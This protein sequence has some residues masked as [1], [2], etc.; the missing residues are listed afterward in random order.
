MQMKKNGW[1]RAG[2]ILS[3]IFLLAGFLPRQ[4]Q[5]SPAPN[6]A[7]EGENTTT[8]GTDGTLWQIDPEKEL[9]LTL[10]CS[11]NGEPL[12]GI[13]FD[14]YYVG[15]VLADGELQMSESFSPYTIARM[16]LSRSDWRMMAETLDGYAQRD[17]VP[18]VMTGKTDDNGILELPGGSGTLVP[19]VY[20]CEAH[21]EVEDDSIYSIEPFLVS[22]P[23]QAEDGTQIYE[24]NVYPKA[25][26]RNVENDVDFTVIKIWKDSETAAGTTGSTAVP[27][28]EASSSDTSTGQ[29]GA[30]ATDS[31]GD[32]SATASISRPAQIEVQLL[33]NGEVQED[34]TV[35]L[36]AANN[37]QYTWTGLDGT[38]EWTAVEKNVPENYTV[39]TSMEDNDSRLVI[40][41]TEKT[42]STDP[43]STE[44]PSTDPA[45]TETPSTD[46]TPTETPLTDPVQSETAQPES[47]SETS[48]S[49][50]TIPTEGPVT[51]M[52]RSAASTSESSK[53]PQTGM[54]WWPV[55][56]LTL[57]GL[58]LFVIGWILNRKN[59]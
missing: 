52:S 1:K 26:R 41:N 3:C 46:P 27:S 39:M 35:T 51:K 9:S 45:S 13:P 16:D 48:S 30:A 31:S 36:S 18:A 50:E 2:A 47:Q 55:P 37:W 53:L 19:G 56:V 38:A 17:E 8:S 49:E 24:V 5:A 44:T 42:P 57:A 23:E 11:C 34:Q 33:K 14:L 15:E 43:T 58:V 29:T 6:T 54:L 12:E 59:D 4:A 20:L 10:H 32:T 25:Q 21:Q 28:T 7:D 22:L 40:T